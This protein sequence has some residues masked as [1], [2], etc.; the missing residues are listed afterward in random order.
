MRVLGFLRIA[1][2]YGLLLW[3]ALAFG[4]YLGWPLAV[5]EMLALAG[6]VLWILGMLAARRIQWRR[7]ALDLPLGL[8]AL[9]V[10]AQLA[11]GNGPLVAWALAPPPADLDLR[12]VFPGRL[13]LLGTVAPPHT[14]EA[15]VTFL[16]YASAYVLVVNL[17]RTRR[18]LERLVGTLLLAGGLLAF[19]ALLDFLADQAWLVPGQAD[20]V[21]GRL[22]GTFVNPDHFGSWLSMLVCLGTGYLLARGRLG[23]SPGSGAGLLASREGREELARRY[24]PFIGVGVMALALVFTLSRGAILGLLVAL[25][26]ILALQGALGRA[27]WSLV[28]VGSLLVVT[29]GYGA[30]IGLEPLLQRVW[31]GDV[32]GRW[33]QTLSTLPML[34]AFPVLGTGLGAYRDIYFRYQPLALGPG[35]MYYAYAH[36]DLLQLLVE[37][38][39]LGAAV[40]LLALWRVGADLVG[41]HLLG[42]G[43][44]PVGGGEDEGARRSEPLSVGVAIGALGA[45]LALLVHSLF[46]FSARVPANGVLAAGCLGLATAA[47]HTRFG[48]TGDR[49][50]TS[51]LGVAIGG[52]GALTVILGGGVV[53][54]GLVAAALVA[55]P[56]LVEAR[57]E[58]AAGV[59]R[60]ASLDR[61]LALDPGHVRT[62]AARGQARLAA[63]RQVW[64]AGEAPDG[65][66][67]ASWEERRREALALLGG[68]GQDLRAALERTPTDPYL[69]ET[70]SWVHAI[71]GF[72]DP[73]SRAEHTRRAFASLHRAIAL[74]PESALMR[75][76]LL[77]LAAGQPEPRLA[78]ALEAAR[79]AL[80]RDPALLP[81]VVDLLAPLGLGVDQWLAAAPDSAEDRLELAAALEQRGLPNEAGQIYRRAAELAPPDQRAL[82]HWLLARL[83]LERGDHRGAAI[84]AEAGL[85]HDPDNPALL[86]A[87]ALALDG[88]GDPE[89]LAAY[90][91]ALASAEAREQRLAGDPPFRSGSKRLRALLARALGQ[92]DAPRPVAYRRAL[93]QYLLDRRLWD[94]AA[95]EWR[96]VIAEAPEEAGAHFRL[97]LALGALQ[98]RAEALEAFR[99]AVAL[100]GRSAA[101]RMRLARSLWDT[102]QYFQAMNEWRA[103][104]ALEPGHLEARLA[105][106]EAH[107]RA[108]DRVEALREYQRILLMVPDQ[109][110]A[111]RGLARLGAGR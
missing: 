95:Q 27:R 28:L 68:A 31:H 86:L 55:R 39:A 99:R 17:V 41:A 53:T 88:A 65:R 96:R 71:A 102:E 87:R 49:P 24:L 103:V 22:A 8:L 54:L 16:T 77:I 60:L 32:S 108:G 74:Q 34:S 110:E 26:A 76:S 44:C 97:G 1:A 82:A 7:T 35:K 93:A 29:L 52:G 90:R 58:G 94:A 6:I 37:T 91:A 89:A 75:R 9:L 59:A 62:L 101:Y 104:L 20:A 4:A 81:E 5:T 79:A 69:H 40:C 48:A 15:L 73:L 106:A 78:A 12:A 85:G 83:L 61:A 80:A 92:A 42:R 38:G 50:L 66:R 72:H 46:D 43:R 45:V 98:R 25:A 51:T 56:A 47:L 36:N 84:E 3:P 67:L 13:L 23:R 14:A 64:A 21:R 63:A 19:L 109:P 2:L 100:D 111:R 105:L 57:L 10:L 70:L 18:S 33:L 11:V 107:A 30:W